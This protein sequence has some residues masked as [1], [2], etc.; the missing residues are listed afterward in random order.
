MCIKSTI[1]L[2]ARTPA[3]NRTSTFDRHVDNFTIAAQK[4]IG[5]TIESAAEKKTNKRGAKLFIIL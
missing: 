3:H 1:N 4:K 2:A 5:R